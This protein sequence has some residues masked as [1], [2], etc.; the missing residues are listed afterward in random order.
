M[1]DHF[2]RG[3]EFLQQGQLAD[4]RTSFEAAVRE[5]PD[6]VLARINELIMEGL[7]RRAANDERICRLG[8]VT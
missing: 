8:V 2:Q 3:V 4:A 5:R 7:H 1:S 6:W